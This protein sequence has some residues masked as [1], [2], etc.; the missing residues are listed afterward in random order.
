MVP[1]VWGRLP[2]TKW[3]VLAWPSP[4][5]HYLCY[6]CASPLQARAAWRSSSCCWRPGSMSTR[7]TSSAWAPCCWSPATATT[8]SSPWCWTPAATRAR[9]TTSATRRCTSPCPARRTNWRRWSGSARSRRR[10]PTAHS[11]GA[12]ST[13]PSRSGRGSTG[14]PWGWRAT[15]SR[16]LRWVSGV[17][18]TPASKLYC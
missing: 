3:R 18:G 12:T 11:T 9:A 7:R 14:T 13:S 8:S 1:S 4:L 5:V 15:R 17:G 16:S 10:P 2:Y 6:S